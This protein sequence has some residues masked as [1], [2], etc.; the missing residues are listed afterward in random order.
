[1]PLVVPLKATPSQVVTCTLN[2]QA[3]TIQVRQLSTGLYVTLFVDDAL[4]ISEVLALNLNVIVRSAYLGFIG[5]LAFFDTQ[6][7]SS[8]VSTELGSRYVLEYFAPSELPAG[9]A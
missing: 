8:P 7:T 5:D 1:M 3:C 2:G 9:L 4:I 6:G